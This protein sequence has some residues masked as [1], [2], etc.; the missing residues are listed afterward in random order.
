ML[1]NNDS[2]NRATDANALRT[3]WAALP[4]T[5]GNKMRDSIKTACGWDRQTWWNRIHGR[6]GITTA[7]KALINQL[8]GKDIFTAPALDPTQ[9]EQTK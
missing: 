9:H 8:A 4:M 2:N 1:E 6:T 7:E 5:E 3:W